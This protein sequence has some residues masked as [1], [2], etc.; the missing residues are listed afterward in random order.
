[1]DA[2]VRILLSML[3]STQEELDVAFPFLMF[4]I[5]GLMMTICIL[6]GLDMPT[7]DGIPSF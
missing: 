2:V 7:A 1:M 5:V 6:L 3:C 4:T